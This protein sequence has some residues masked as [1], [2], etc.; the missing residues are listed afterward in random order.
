[1]SENDVSFVNRL[2]SHPAFRAGSSY[3]VIAFIAVQVMSLVGS[4]FNLSESL[5]QSVIWATIIGFPIVIFLSIIISSQF[6]TAKLLGMAFAIISIGYLGWAFYFIQVVKSPQLEEAVGQDEYAK[7]WLI[8]REINDVF[9]FISQIQDALSQLSRPASI[10]IKQDNVDVFWKPYG[11]DDFEWEFLGTDMEQTQQ[12]PVG[13]IQLRLEKDGY[14]TAYISSV[15]PSL[16]FKNFPGDMGFQAA[17]MELVQADSVPPGMVYVPGGPFV[18][19]ISGDSLKPYVLSPYFIDKFEVTNSQFKAFIDDGGYKNPRYWEEMDFIKDGTSL[20]FEQALGLM[21]DQTGRNGPANWELGDFTEGRDDFPVTG[22]SWYEAQA[23]AK[24]M[25]NILPPYFHWA[26]A[27]FPLDEWVS[28]LAPEM[29]SR[30]NFKGDSVAKVG[31][32][33]SLGPYGTYDMT[34]NVA[35]WVWNIFGGRGMT[36][37]GA[38]SQPQYT[39]FQANP[40]PR[41]NRSDLVGFRTV[42]LLNSADL[43]PFGGPID[44]PAPPPKEFFKPLN[45]DAFKLYSTQFSYSRR[46]LKAKVIYVD[47]THDDW[48]KEKISIDVGYSNERMDVLIFKPKNTYNNVGSVVLYPGLNYFRNPPDLDDIDPGEYGLDFI[49]KSGRALVWVAFKGSL[50]RIVDSSIAQPSTQDNLRQFRQMMIDWRVDSGRVL[51]YLEDR[52]DFANDKFHYM[53]MSYGAVY[54]PIVLLSEKRYKSAVFLSGGFSP[55]APPHSD[56]IFYLNRVDTPTL[57]L[58]GEQ[59]FLLPIE[60]QEAMFEGLGVAPKD[61]RYVLFKA[62]HWPLPRSKMVNETLSWFNK[63]EK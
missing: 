38:V 62:G 51:D 52:Q 43:N 5:I 22:I 18:P 59:D 61:K 31:E 4:S 21:V 24:Y 14:E 35:E 2:K 17:K 10:N 48:I 26:K 11:S 53:G 34:G 54:M 9:P 30:S 12:L 15:N 25:G 40:M 19:A 37:G 29:L 23:Y 32:F 50:N 55:Y 41:F 45:D 60:S 57:M 16:L 42:R 58:N 8:A 44:R 49:I 3:A 56:G 13:G 33:D 39:G 20:T 28:P 1:M 7:S 46:D 6:S 47:D 27:A 63:Y 36:L